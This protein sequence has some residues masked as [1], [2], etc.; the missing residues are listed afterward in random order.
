MPADKLLVDADDNMHDDRILLTID[1]GP[2][3]RA[4]ALLDYLMERRI[5]AILFCEGAKLRDRRGE[6]IRAIKEGY[7]IGNHSYDHPFFEQLLEG[8]AME[9]IAKTDYE[10]ELLHRS[11]QRQR[12]ARY[13]RFP[14]GN[15]CDIEVHQRL[16]RQ[17]GYW[18]P[19]G[20]AQC[21]WRWEIEVWDWQVDARN[22]AGK[23]EFAKG[24]LAGTLPRRKI[25]L[26]HDHP[27]NFELELFQNICQA[28]L[29]TGLRF[30][31]NEDLF[32]Q[33]TAG[34]TG[35]G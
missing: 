31:T 22:M 28:V 5:G 24:R 3:E 7:I 1:D 16:L 20:G 2:S 6:A 29:D 30:W 26:L 15:G 4:G 23:L 34:P 8:Q 13:F 10:I 11:A 12:A 14:Y 19:F 32:E 35:S 9:Q 18:S 27:L 33:A 21:D 25:L 17:R